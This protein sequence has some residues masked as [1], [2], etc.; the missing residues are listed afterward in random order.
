[1]STGSV[2]QIIVHNTSSLLILLSLIQ[3]K[4]IQKRYIVYN[5]INIQGKRMN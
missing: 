1:M 3:Y 4:N 5:P 2:A